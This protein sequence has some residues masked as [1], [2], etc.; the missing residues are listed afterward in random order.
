MPH[1]AVTMLEH[2]N[3]LANVMT[4]ANGVAKFC[5]APVRPVDFVVGY[6]E[7]GVVFVKGVVF[8]WP[9]PRNIYVVYD[10]LHCRGELVFP[11]SCQF[12]LRTRSAN[13]EPL[14]GVR[15]NDSTIKNGV[16]DDS[17][18]IF[19]NI[20][21]GGLLEGTLEKQGWERVHITKRC[22]RG[23]EGDLELDIAMH[24]LEKH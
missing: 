9:E 10:Q 2:E 22:T 8:R 23:D 16:S 7:C 5:D 21:S 24:P 19:T 17:G 12:L 11:T 1:V 4:D 18:R 13:G 6:R 14:P 3:H 15:L 20:R